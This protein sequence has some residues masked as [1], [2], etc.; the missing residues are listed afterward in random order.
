M[1]R[2]IFLRNVFGKVR[3]VAYFLEI[4]FRKYAGSHTSGKREWGGMRR[5]IFRR[6]VIRKVCVV[7][8]SSET[9]SGKYAGSHTLWKCEREGTR[10]RILCRNV[11][12]KVCM[13]AYFRKQNLESTRGRILRR[14]VIGRVI[15]VRT[16]SV[17]V[18]TSNLDFLRSIRGENKGKTSHINNVLSSK[19]ALSIEQ[20]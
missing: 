10:C 8:Y 12:G 5:R 15:H 2:R 19:Q 20:S 11:V 3:V 17:L 1:R 9:G 16:Y 6:N 7:A 14:T 13:V 4:R 18:M